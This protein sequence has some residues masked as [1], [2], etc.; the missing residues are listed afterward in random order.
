[1]PAPLLPL[2]LGAAAVWA[3]T[4]WK[5][6]QPTTPYTGPLQPVPLMPGAEAYLP[7][8]SAPEPIRNLMANALY[9]NN[10]TA[11]RTTAKNLE[12]LGYGSLAGPLLA[13]ADVIDAQKAK[14]IAGA[15]ALMNPRVRAYG[16]YVGRSLWRPPI[17]LAGD[18][19]KIR[20]AR[21]LARTA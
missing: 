9:A 8:V 19:E 10:P 17:A 11:L 15:I 1:M 21:R 13:R 3:F 20:R 2:A 7:P 6:D 4:Q 14:A 12:A 5:K 16:P 18:L